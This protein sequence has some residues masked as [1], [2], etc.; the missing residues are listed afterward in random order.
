MRGVPC[1]CGAPPSWT[2]ARARGQGVDV[3]R[4]VQAVKPGG[5]GG[6]FED[7]GPSRGRPNVLVAVPPPQVGA[8]GGHRVTTVLR[9]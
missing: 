7:F 6:L 8:A 9:D 3:L 5:G 4:V 1:P 2:A